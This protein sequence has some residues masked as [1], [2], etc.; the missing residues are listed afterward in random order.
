MSK[1]TITF[2]QA[3]AA[4]K[5]LAEGNTPDAIVMRAL[6]KSFETDELKSLNEVNP[7]TLDLFLQDESNVE[8]LPDTS[9]DW[10]SYRIALKNEQIV[11]QQYSEDGKTVIATSPDF[12]KATIDVIK[13]HLASQLSKSG[14]QSLTTNFADGSMLTYKTT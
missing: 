7:V 14:G 2:Q 12:T 3:A 10:N 13:D 6:R 11:I 4:R 1:P 9:I 8:I 5:L